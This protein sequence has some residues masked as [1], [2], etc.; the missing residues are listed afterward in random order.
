MASGRGVEISARTADEAIAQALK[1]LRLTREDVEVEV[2]H[3]GSP[4]RLLGFGA[5]P[6]RIRVTPR[7]EAPEIVATIADVA[8]GLRSTDH[9][10]E[11]NEAEAL[12]VDRAARMAG[13]RSP[14]T[15]AGN[16]TGEGE[17]EEERTPESLRGEAELA[18]LML[19]ELLNRM[20]ITDA[21]VELAGV[22][23]VM[24][25]IV[26]DELADLIGRRGENLRAIQFVLN[27]M[28][29][30]QLRRRLRVNLDV[31]GYRTRREDLL[32]GMAERFAQRVRTT[33]EAMQLETMP[34]NE[35]R[36]IHL[37]L[38]DD[39]DVVS[40]SVGEGES[41]RVVIKPRP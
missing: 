41:R 15:A 21:T 36:I 7:S 38:A 26:G 11:P 14:A 24:L 3:P 35:R 28:L 27:L 25:N 37:V 19:V 22:E 17:E 12:A 1:Q 33:H 31:D 40:E 13:G 23:P 6:A 39:P 4:G 18:R 16:A 32:R 2:L 9:E 5:E 8:D 34:P 20:G 10:D 30:K 29:N